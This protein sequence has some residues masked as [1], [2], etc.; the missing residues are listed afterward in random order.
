M[1][2][3]LQL[4]N[5]SNGVFYAGQVVEAVVQVHAQHEEEIRGIKIKYKGKA[6]VEWKEGSGEEER[7]YDAK[8]KYFEHEQW[9]ISGGY[10]LQPGTNSYPVN[11]ILPPNLPSS[12]ESY[13]GYIRYNVKAKVDREGKDYKVQYPF[14]VLSHVDLNLNPN[15]AMPAQLQDSKMICCLC[16]ATGPVTAVFRIDRSG[17]VPGEAIVINAEIVNN[18]DRSISSS[19]VK[20][21]MNL[22]YYA[23]GNTRFEKR[24]VAKVEHGPI[25]PHG[26]D[27]WSG[28]RLVI[29]PIPPSPLANCNIIHMEYIVELKADVDNT[30]F[31]LEVPL[32]VIIGTVPLQTYLPPPVPMPELPVDPNGIM[33]SEAGGQPITVQPGAIPIVPPPSYGNCVFGKVDIT[34]EREGD[35]RKMM[36]YTPQY[37]YYNYGN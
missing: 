13:Y 35:E 22:R 33:L 20:L 31:D 23:D 10:V 15:C 21:I 30:P 18:S 19:R 1:K 12:F 26:S 36:E 28:D 34:S 9:I 16:C 11:F 5:S 2:L 14:T 4:V 25:E 7:E 24:D 32:N 37:A 8:E 6:K 29:P 27:V 17:Y 3:D